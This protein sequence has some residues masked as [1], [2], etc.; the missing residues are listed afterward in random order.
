MVRW[1]QISPGMKCVH[2][3]LIVGPQLLTLFPFQILIQAQ[4]VGI[5]FLRI[6]QASLHVLM[7]TH[8]GLRDYI[9]LSL[10]RAP[11][12]AHSCGNARDLMPCPPPL[13]KWTGPSRPSPR[14]RRLRKFFQLRNSIVQHIV[15]VLNWEA[16]GHCKRPPPRA[17]VGA[18]ISCEQLNLLQRIEDLVDHFASAGDF[19][20]GSL[21][22]SADKLS[23]ILQAVKE[24]P[25]PIQ[26]VDLMSVMSFVESDLN[27]YG[28]SKW[29][30]EASIK[31]ADP[32]CSSSSDAGFPKASDILTSGL[33]PP[34]P[35]V[36]ALGGTLEGAKFRGHFECR[37]PSG[38]PAAFDITR[39]EVDI[40][41]QEV[42][43]HIDASNA[44][45]V[46]A[47][48]IKWE[49]SPTFD[50]RPYLVDPVVKRAFEDPN[51]LRL[52]ESRWKKQPPGKIHC[53]RSEVLKLAEKWDAVGALR[54][55]PSHEIDHS[56]AVGI[57][58]VGK[59]QMFDRL[60]LNPVVVNGRMKHYSNYTRTLAPGCLIGLI[61][62]QPHEVVRI[63]ADDLSEMYY[64]FR[65]P[66]KRARRNALRM[67]FHCHELS[68]FKCFNPAI[69]KG[70]CYLALG[71]LAMGDSLAVEIA[72]QAHHQVL[73]QLAGCMQESERV[74]YRRCF[75]RGKFFEFLAIDDHLGLQVLS[76]ADFKKQK[77]LRDVEV[78]E[79]AGEAYRQVGLVQHPRKRRRC[80]TSGIFLGAEVDGVR[81]RVSAPRHRIG[82]LMLCTAI[83]AYKGFT[84]R[85]LLN[86]VT[87]CWIHVLM[88]RRPILSVMSSVFSDGSE[89]PLD[90]VFKLSQQSRNE[91]FALCVLGPV[92]QTDLRTTTSDRIFCLDASPYGGGI[93]EA[94]ESSSVVAELWRH[95]EQR[96]YYTKLENPAS[97]V[98]QELGL[99]SEPSYGEHSDNPLFPV[100]LPPPR[101]LREGFIF[102][103][104]ELFIGEGNWTKAH[105]E[106]GLTAHPGV[107][108]RGD[109]LRFGDLLDPKVWSQLLSFALRGVIR[110]WHAG[111]P[112][113]TFGTLRRPRIRSKARPAGFCM[114]DPLTAEQNSLAWRTAFLLCIAMSF[115][116]FISVEQ[117]GNS[118]MFYM[119]AFRTLALK[120]CVLSRFCFCAYGSGF[121]KPSRW[122]HNKPWLL[123][124]ESRCS[125]SGPDRHCIIEGT[126]TREKIAEFESK[127]RPNS[128]AVY[129]RPPHRGE[130]VA[131]YSASYP[132][133]LVRRAALG[134]MAHK[135]GSSII[136]PLSRK[137]ATL[138][139]L[140]VF[141]SEFAGGASSEVPCIRPWHED[142]DW[143][144]ELADSV[145]FHEILRYKFHRSGHINVLEARVYKTWLK[146]CAKRFPSHRLLGLLDSRVT[147]GAA[148]KGRSSSFAISRV[149]QG[150]LGYIIGGNLYPGGLHVCSSKN[151]SDGPS[152]NRPVPGPTKDPPNWL[153][154]LRAGNAKT[155]DVTTATSTFARG[156]GRWLRLLLLL[157]GD[158]ERNP[159][160]I[161]QD[162]PRVKRGH[163]DFDVGFAQATSKRMDDCL[164]SFKIWIEEQM[165]GQFN[166]LCQDAQHLSMALRGY[167]CFLYEQGYPRYLLTYTITG[168]Q[169]A[170]PHFRG[171]L[172]AAWQI[173]KKWQTM[174]PGECRPVLSAPVMRAM[175]STALLWG[176]HFWVAVSMVGFLGMLHPAE[177]LALTRRAAAGCNDH[178]T[179]FV[180]ACEKSQNSSFC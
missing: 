53:S 52:D 172:Q 107:D 143:I 170:F 48:R 33:G 137:I 176:W 106:V 123:E 139:E 145:N 113:F 118:V 23:R 2:I 84:T 168:I 20:A 141:D 41:S 70:T 124:V 60:I 156:P 81:G 5:L 73:F 171:C 29:N 82:L 99:D 117:P 31:S 175:V 35:P 10:A 111:P 174:E 109:G 64:T 8:V 59:D 83:V 32:D 6:L 75:P 67:K 54:I 112:C 1:V 151:R 148:A 115:G 147:L 132:L 125:C 57:F 76:H 36:R 86:S 126:F 97:A 24:L 155:F 95:S 39:G 149:L 87:G 96:G 88:F 108:V 157:C 104:I 44:K 51:S 61:Q 69:H 121:K 72:Q 180:C 100:Y 7:R 178:R 65:V 21:C 102:D 101:C 116:S 131:S 19:D 91:L 110:D 14:R 179:D 165:P 47:D 25:G 133:P 62:L 92:A 159:G 49:H 89:F 78:F 9:L 11:H 169:D 74:C 71:S 93:C 50:P 154:Q 144:G 98:L 153:L 58:A 103:V 167:G 4:T 45:P 161:R 85:R 37:R 63:S 79:R 142:P 46:I 177:F 17:C 160:P 56:E 40:A 114:S 162:P 158:I 173:D 22:R 136:I 135:Q 30:R 146:H 16:L 15:C 166:K 127:C 26:D 34:N 55:F 152:R 128:S 134:A 163:F 119:H 28:N 90:K 3:I 129:G 140:G 43:M 38:N 12:T 120:G 18:D 164:R 130:S 150:C 138:Q 68:R 94:R 66:D 42:K 80:V 13:W 105:V 122:L 77:R 27:S